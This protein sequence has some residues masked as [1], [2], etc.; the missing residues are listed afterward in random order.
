MYI[1]KFRLLF[2][3]VE[4]FVRDY[5]I[6]AGQT[7]K[8]F[9]DIIVR[10]ITGL[11]KQELASFYICDRRWEK[12]IEITLIDMDTDEDINAS[13]EE[14]ISKMIMSDSVLSDFID[15]PHQRL[16]YEYD[17]FNVKT[18]YIEL[19]KTTEVKTRKKY[20]RCIHHAGEIPTS[21]FNLS[22]ESLNL[23][24]I[25]DDSLEDEEIKDYYDEEDI[26]SLNEDIEI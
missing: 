11:G 8:E 9:H 10:T 22:P 25:E 26:Q 14:N 5:E 7:F 1:Y 6:S 17:F 20:P 4:D 15:D 3:E 21:M 18:F 16:I 12:K 2:D 19:L 23:L 24:D 13:D